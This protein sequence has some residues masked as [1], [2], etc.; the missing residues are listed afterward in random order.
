MGIKSLP[1]G[2][3]VR[4]IGAEIDDETMY[5]FT[6][7]VELMYPRFEPQGGVEQLILEALDA[8]IVQVGA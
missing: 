2:G 7:S 8:I 4:L 1:T 6:T 3:F 5:V